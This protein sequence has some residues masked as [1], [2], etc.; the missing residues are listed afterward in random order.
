MQ[1]IEQLEDMPWCVCMYVCVCMC[2]GVICTC[3][4]ERSCV[5]MYKYMYVCI[6][7][8]S[9]LQALQNT[10]KGRRKEYNTSLGFALPLHHTHTHTHTYTH[11]HT[12][13]HI[14]IAPKKYIC[15]RSCTLSL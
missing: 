5:R 8:S 2:V 12:H 10:H 7:V 14:P 11:T 1:A 4:I 13:T 3:S 9:G 6:K 15:I